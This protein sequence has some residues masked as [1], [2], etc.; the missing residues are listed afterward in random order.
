[1]RDQLFQL[2]K[3]DLHRH[4]EGAVRP[5][6]IADIC[7]D[8]GVP[9]PTYDPDELA[10]IVQLSGQVADLG[11]FLIPFRTIKMCFVDKEAIAR[12]AF[13]AVED[14]HL[15]NIRYVELRFSPEFMAFYYKLALTDVMDGIVE[16][17]ESAARRY[18]DTTAK[19]I[20]SISR[21][22]SEV[23]MHMP[24]PNPM[25]IAR[26]ALD[27]ADRGVVGLDIAGRE[28][29]YPP[30]LFV[31]P[32]RMIREAGLGIT[33]HA[34][35][36]AGPESVRGA[37]ESLG[38]TRIGHG[39][40]VVGD[41][42]VVALVKDRGVFLELCPTSN[43]L[44]RAVESMASHPVRRL[45]DDGVPITINT[46]DPSVCATTLTHEYELLV[47]HFG[48]TLEEIRDL[49]AAAESAAFA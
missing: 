21:D 24:W 29:G 12:I 34:G 48:F 19:L 18:P 9:L 40:R 20:I 5:A 16:G 30:E 11:Q 6:T 8:R 35:E 17:I 32:F 44:T 3:I 15:D 41:P 42:E 14:A 31:D 10:K 2:P 26:L 28:D 36:D 33:A 1:M 25:E 45:F 49:V 27:Y 22:L 7:R 38:A 4:L 43:V 46:D 47:D 39:V 13:E 23:T 37:I